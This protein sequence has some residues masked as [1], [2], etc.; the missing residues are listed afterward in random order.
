MVDPTGV[1]FGGPDQA[2]GRLRDLLAERVA[3]VPAGGAIDWVTYYFRDRRLASE[4]V[5]ARKR[6]V[7][8]KVTIE[9]SPRTAHA[10]EAVR[11]ILSGADGLDG[12]FRSVAHALFP[13][14]W[15]NL[16]S[17]HIH[18]KLFCFS[19]PRPIA[20]VGSFNPSGDVP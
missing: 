14:P 10:N 16:P 5:K 18:E 20:L 17:A 12:G 1:Y 2:P 7:A 13:T 8:V 3:A 4:L 15:G 9:R 6:G 19:H 11:R